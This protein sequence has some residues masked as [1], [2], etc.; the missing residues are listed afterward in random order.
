MSQLHFRVSKEWVCWLII[1]LALVFTYSPLLRSEYAL[2]DDYTYFFSAASSEQVYLADGRPIYALAQIFVHPSIHSL[3]QLTYLRCMA[4]GGTIGLAI[5]FF[6]IAR[7]LGGTKTE[8]LAFAIALG[9]LPCLHDVIG[10]ALLWLVPLAG[11]FACCACV[12]TFRHLGKPNRPAL[13]SLGLALPLLLMLVASMIY[14]PMISLYWTVTLVFSLDPR[15]LSSKVYRSQIFRLVFLGFVYF[16]ICYV[17]FKLVFFLSDVVPKSRTELA[18]NP[19]VKLYWFFRIQLPIALNY[20]KLVVAGS[21]WVPLI[22]A[23]GA[24]LVIFA[25]YCI[26]SR[27]YYGSMATSANKR[28]RS[29][30]LIQRSIVVL[31]LVFLSHLHWLAIKDLP[32]SYRILVPLGVSAWVLLYWGVSEIMGLIANSTIC[33]RV[34]RYVFIAIAVISMF[35]CQHYSEAYLVTPYSLA[36]RYVLYC[37]REGLQPEIKSIHVICQGPEDGL[38]P[39]YYIE[40][41][42]RPPSESSWMIQDWLTLALRDCGIANHVESITHGEAHEPIPA[43]SSTLVIDMRKLVKFRLSGG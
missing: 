40:S 38:V 17:A 3:W 4:V 13:E 15:F 26:S 21:R 8:R 19:I 7:H 35:V 2:A 24:G 37:L 41:F 33:Q 20:W 29:N 14:Q 22:T 34:R 12:L 42:G 27:R 9:T 6:G 18:T 30:V 23:A 1:A 36:H 16:A 11:L 39:T 28:E 43:S 31:A 25:G 32:Q 10:M 5:V